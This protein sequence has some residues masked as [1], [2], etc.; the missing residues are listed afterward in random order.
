M[1]ARVRHPTK[2]LRRADLRELPKLL[3]GIKL[4]SSRTD[5]YPIEQVQLVGFYGKTWV[6]F[7]KVMKR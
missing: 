7:G 6:G 1:S 4:T 3:P 5:F 2:P